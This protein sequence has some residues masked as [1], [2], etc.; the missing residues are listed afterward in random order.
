M[1]NCNLI[2][3]NQFEKRSIYFDDLLDDRIKS[4]SLNIINEFNFRNIIRQYKDLNYSLNDLLINCRN[5]DIQ[6]LI[7]YLNKEFEWNNNGTEKELNTKDEENYVNILKEKVA[8]KIYKILPQD[9]IVILPDNNIIKKKYIEMK[10]IICLKDYI[11]NK[12]NKIYKISIIYTFSGINDMIE[13]LNYNMSLTFMKYVIE[14]KNEFKRIINEIKM[15]NE[16]VNLKEYYIYI[17]LEKSDIEYIKYIINFILNNFKEDKYN[18]IILMH[19]NRNFSNNGE[20][21]FSLTDINPDINQL[22]ID[23]LN[24]NNYLTL[25]DILTYNIKDLLNINKELFNLDKEFNK[26]LKNFLIKKLNYG[27]H[28][29]D[30]KEYIKEITNYIN[31]E[32]IIKEKIFEL[33]IK[34]ID[35][36]KEYKNSKNIIELIYKNELINKYSVDIVSCFKEY[37]IEGIYNKYLRKIFLILEDNNIFITLLEFKKNNYK[38]INKNIVIDIILKYLDA[39]TIEKNSR[40][41]SKF[42]FHYNVPILNNFYDSLSNYI[43]IYTLND[44][45]NNEKKLRELLKEDIIIIKEFHKKEE[46]LLDDTFRGFE[47]IRTIRIIHR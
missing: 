19:I 38:Y 40:Y 28:T 41:K 45:T 13:G 5:H 27:P 22:F 32:E 43:N 4:I 31:D 20:N 35:N 2:F 37:I 8:N 14:N 34:L 33:V 44:Y 47:E 1:N 39:I 17:H 42:L 12:E 11:N 9:I 26:A 16:R 21:I 24:G 46:I 25:K 30:Y 29:E 3:L 15:K 18:Y 10:N 6:K 7:Y 23:N 36:S